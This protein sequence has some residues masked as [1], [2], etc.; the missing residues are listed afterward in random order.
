MFGFG[1]RGSAD[2]PAVPSLEPKHLFEKRAT[3]DNARLRAYNQILGQIHNRIYATAQ[4]P[5]N[6]NSLV[7]TVPPFILGLPA[8][9]LQDCIVYLVSILRN[10]GFVVRYTY[11][12]LLYISWKH[13]ESQYN[14]EQN[15]IVQ[16]MM[17][18]AVP[19]TKKGK[20][21]KRGLPQNGGQPLGVTFAPLPNEFASGARA[22]PKS[23][24]EYSPPDSFLES[25]TR[26]P[27]EPAPRRD[28]PP[29][30]Q[31]QTRSS[32]DVLADLWKFQ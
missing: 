6:T 8:I 7:Y 18:P 13:Y 25:L 9:D 27:V 3:R 1:P 30:P 23:T 26:P 14:R 31:P 28:G 12:N 10:N 2:T 4:L 29:V 32:A 15:P 20:E 17:P 16:A 22:P 21:G 5:Q 11:P 19:T 24:A